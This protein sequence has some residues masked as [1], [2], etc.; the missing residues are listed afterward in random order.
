[1]SQY[2][3]KPYRKKC[4]TAEELHRIMT[5]PFHRQTLYHVRDMF[6]FSCF[7]GIP[8]GDMRLL[9]KEK[10]CLAEDGTW[11]IKSARQKTRIEFEIPLLE[12]PLQILNKYRD[13]A[14][15]DKLLPMYYNSMLNL[16]LKEIVRICNISRPLVFYAGR[17]TYC[18][19]NHTFPRSAP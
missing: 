6:L 9:A 4:L 8:Y 13:T 1:M 15:G 11:W 14:P 10:L 12:L 19:R 18:H 5:T 2:V 7:T 3:Q 17:H 16:Y